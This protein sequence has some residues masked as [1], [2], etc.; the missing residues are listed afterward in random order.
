MFLSA[1]WKNPMQTWDRNW[2]DK[3]VASLKILDRSHR[4]MQLTMSNCSQHD[5]V[6]STVNYVIYSF[7]NALWGQFAALE[8]MHLF[9]WC[10]CRRCNVLRQ[11]LQLTQQL[12]RPQLE[13][14]MQAPM[15]GWK[16]WPQA[17]EGLLFKLLA[18]MVFGFP[19][20]SPARSAR[21][22]T[23]GPVVWYSLW[24]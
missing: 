15:K 9:H 8:L 1:K 17:V 16:Q 13:Y 5:T 2:L 11:V 4:I 10:R 12:G 18:W 20:A 22:K 24:R 7:H 23:K 14:L 19:A 3:L 21:C 6:E